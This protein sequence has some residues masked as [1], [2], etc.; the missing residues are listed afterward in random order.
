M[1][2]F[3]AAQFRANAFVA[4]ALGRTGVRK[5]GT[6]QVRAVTERKNTIGLCAPDAVGF[7]RPRDGAVC[8]KTAYIDT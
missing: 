1:F 4:V 2:I 6:F 7:N 3:P 8:A 5:L